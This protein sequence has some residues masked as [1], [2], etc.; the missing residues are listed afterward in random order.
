MPRRGS[1]TH[2]L[3]GFTMR[4]P[5]HNRSDDI[6]LTVPQSSQMRLDSPRIQCF[7]LTTSR[8]PMPTTCSSV[9]DNRFLYLVLL[10]YYYLYMALALIVPNNGEYPKDIPRIRITCPTKT[11]CLVEIPPPHKITSWWLAPCRS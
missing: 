1:R 10:Y 9:T 4:A 2:S 7:R 5:N 6:T 11:V 8:L 3:T